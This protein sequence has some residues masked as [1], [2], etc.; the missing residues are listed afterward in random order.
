MKFLNRRKR[1]NICLIFVIQF[2]IINLCFYINLIL[3]KYIDEVLKTITFSKYCLIY[4]TCF[5]LNNVEGF[6]CK[7]Q[8]YFRGR[9]LLIG[10]KSIT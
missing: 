7:V 5:S 1:S 2:D 9:Y 6:Y 8:E 10:L 4:L 3:M